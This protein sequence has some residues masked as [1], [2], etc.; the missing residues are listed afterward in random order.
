MALRISMPVNLKE[1]NG[2][3]AIFVPM[4]VRHDKGGDEDGGVWLSMV[5]YAT[6]RKIMLHQNGLVTNEI[7][8]GPSLAGADSLNS[9]SPLVRSTEHH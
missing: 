2:L 6:N 5:S 1:A 9:M 4:L 3:S 8:E 7:A